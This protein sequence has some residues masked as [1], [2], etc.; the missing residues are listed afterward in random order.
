MYYEVYFHDN[1]PIKML[2]NDFYLSLCG[3][4]GQVAFAEEK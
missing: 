4:Y 2:H 1:G 3:F